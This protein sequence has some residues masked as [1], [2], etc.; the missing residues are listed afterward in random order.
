MSSLS[1]NVRESDLLTSREE[2]CEAVGLGGRSR[3]GLGNQS[4]RT[5]PVAEESRW[6]LV[7]EPG[8]RERKGFL[9]GNCKVRAKCG[10]YLE[11]YRTSLWKEKESQRTVS[12]SER[13]GSPEFPTLISLSMV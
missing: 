9:E 12:R 4:G 13:G 7:S 11:E 8:E 2:L 3:D 6:K 1:M 5:T 10:H